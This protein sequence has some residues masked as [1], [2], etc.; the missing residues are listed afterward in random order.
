[1]DDKDF[2]DSKNEFFE[3]AANTYQAYL[4]I[5]GCW[6]KDENIGEC[7]FLWNSICIYKTYVLIGSIYNAVETINSLEN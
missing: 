6:S 2:S 4:P 5:I 1:M 3:T 7:V